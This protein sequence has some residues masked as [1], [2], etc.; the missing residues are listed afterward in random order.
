MAFVSIKQRLCQASEVRLTAHNITIASQSGLNTTARGY[1]RGGFDSLMLYRSVMIL[2]IA[3]FKFSTGPGYKTGVG[4][5]HTGSG[6][7]GW[8][9]KSKSATCRFAMAILLVCVPGLRFN[10]FELDY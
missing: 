4:G 10:V 2:T 1:D 8:V 7:S 6:G 5:T 9:K 3:L